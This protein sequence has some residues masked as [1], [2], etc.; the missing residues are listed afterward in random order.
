MAQEE[1]L[2]LSRPY[3]VLINGRA[4]TVLKIGHEK[5]EALIR[6]NLADKLGR[7]L[8]LEGDDFDR[9]CEELIQDKATPLL[10]GG[11]DGTIF[12]FSQRA[13]PAGRA[14]GVLPLGTMNL[15]AIDVGVPKD[16]EAALLAF[17]SADTINI[18]CG[19]L[20]DQ[21]F[22][23]CASV[24]LMP[25]AAELRE[26][27]RSDFPLQSFATLAHKIF[28]ELDEAHERP[29]RIKI[30]NRRRMLLRTNA[31]VIA[32]NEYSAMPDCPDHRFKRCS[33]TDRHLCIYSATP[34]GMW[35]KIRLFFHFWRGTWAKDSAVYSV[36]AHTV[37][38]LGRVNSV[39]IS[40]DGE[41]RTMHM[42]LRAEILPGVVKMI[43]PK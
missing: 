11:G 28:T 8:L 30:N 22:L 15:L 37:E 1:Q 36:P 41:V 23:C 21:Y 25:E 31:L 14:F 3:T 18:D 42:P 24:G 7:F 40:L 20:N 43:V 4:G 12:A 26:E 9:A 6:E 19:K 5:L 35:A 17:K 34:H 32:N 33:L 10:I 16:L 29:F 38:I 27:T 39:R 13:I 2:D